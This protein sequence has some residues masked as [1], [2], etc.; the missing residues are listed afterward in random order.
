MAQPF[1]VEILYQSITQDDTKRKRMTDFQ[2]KRNSQGQKIFQHEV[3][4]HARLFF[5]QIEI[6]RMSTSWF[7]IINYLGAITRK[8]YQP[9][10]L[11]NATP[12]CLSR[13]YRMTDAIEAYW[14]SYVLFA[15]FFHL[16]LQYFLTTSVL[17]IL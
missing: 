6:F 16:S 9:S 5:T 12:L 4:R 11:L 1:Q 10:L 13:V 7:L 8:G 3:T 15:W 2:H 14:K 17:F